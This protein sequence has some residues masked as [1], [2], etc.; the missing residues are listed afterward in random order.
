M[1]RNDTKKTQLQAH[2]KNTE[3]YT[4]IKKVGS[5]SYGTVFKA[6]KN[7]TQ[8]QVAIKFIDLS[9][10]SKA[11][12]ISICREISLN[13]FLAKQKQNCFTVKLLDVYL[14]LDVDVQ[15]PSTIKGIYLVFEYLKYTLYDI[16]TK[17]TSPLTIEQTSVLAYNL[18]CA[19]KYLHS[20]NVIH[21]D[22]KLENILVTSHMEVKICDFG[23]A[24]TLEAQSN[25]NKMKRS[26]ST[27]CFTRAYRPP[28]VILGS[29]TYDESADLWSLGCLL[30]IIV[31]K[32]IKEPH[33]IDVLFSGDSCYP[34]SPMKRAN[35]S[36]ESSEIEVSS[37]DHLIEIIKAL[38][39]K[40]EE[41][42]SLGHST[43]YLE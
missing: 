10:A 13:Q 4:F 25:P 32:T 31:Q 36:S 20:C 26:L 2:Q 6:L 17:T 9:K 29:Q 3:A 43:S 28:E 8:Q 34:Q 23:L 15:D 42:L 39:V 18:I 37:G 22:L 27:A 38:G 12:L 5:G 21:R 41:A 33:E 30:G 7:T 11:L 35:Q 1:I 19:V 24:R 14:P 40:K 16:I